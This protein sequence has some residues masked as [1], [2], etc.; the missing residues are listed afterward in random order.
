MKPVAGPVT[1][2]SGVED[3]D[4]DLTAAAMRALLF[5]A[6]GVYL[7]VL[8]AGVLAGVLGGALVRRHTK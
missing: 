1:P 7:G 8:A 3:L 4:P 6:G 2:S 5:E